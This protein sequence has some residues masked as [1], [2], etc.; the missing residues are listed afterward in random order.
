MIWWIVSAHHRWVNQNAVSSA[1]W[2]S[3]LRVSSLLPQQVQ[4]HAGIS[5]VGG[6][7]VAAPTVSNTSTSKMLDMLATFRSEL[8]AELEHT[9]RI[10][11]P[12]AKKPRQ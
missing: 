9:Q 3:V 12:S 2:H 1:G 8:K 6:S 11:V 4:V 5:M 10:R 7:H